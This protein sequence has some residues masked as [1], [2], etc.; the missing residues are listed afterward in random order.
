MSTASF[1]SA[2]SVRRVEACRA[3]PSRV[4]IA[5]VGGG[6]MGVSTAYWMARSGVEVLLLEAGTMACG[7][8]S[9]NAGLV[10]PS[11]SPL[12]APLILESVLSDENIEADYHVGGHLSLASSDETWDRFRAEASCRAKTLPK[13]L[14]LDHGECESFLN[15]RIGQRFRGGRWYPDGAVI[16]PVRL[17]D[18]L[19]E[20]A[21]RAGAQIHCNTRVQKVTTKSEVSGSVLQIQTTRGYLE[22]DQVVYACNTGVLDLIPEVARALESRVGQVLSSEPMPPLFEC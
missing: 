7:A 20:A 8:S 9:R 18:G 13:L 15:M 1:W 12:E 21:V 4:P 19:S 14:A 11:M 22:A 10:L 16:D 2:S 6:I 5:I 17:V 3:L